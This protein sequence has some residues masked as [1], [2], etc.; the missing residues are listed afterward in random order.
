[1]VCVVGCAE[2]PSPTYIIPFRLHQWNEIKVSFANYV[3]YVN[4][5]MCTDNNIYLILTDF[6]NGVKIF[7]RKDFKAAKNAFDYGIMRGP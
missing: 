1:M 5:C 7:R 6:R 2:L 3:C 4:V